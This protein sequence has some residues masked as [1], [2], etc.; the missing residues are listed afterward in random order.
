MSS[1]N[2]NVCFNELIFTLLLNVSSSVL[3]KLFHMTGIM[4]CKLL[5]NVVVFIEGT[6]LDYSYFL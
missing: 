3:S 2:F 5:A 1:N 4:Y 6:N